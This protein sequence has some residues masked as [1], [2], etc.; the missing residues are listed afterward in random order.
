[1]YHNPDDG[2]RET[3]GG[4][5]MCRLFSYPLL[6]LPT[7]RGGRGRIDVFALRV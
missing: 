2:E 6:L 1:M 3:V 5:S 4:T 7:H